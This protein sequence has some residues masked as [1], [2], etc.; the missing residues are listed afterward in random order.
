MTS[1]EENPQNIRQDIHADDSG[2]AFVQGTGAQHNNVTQN[3][4]GSAGLP[5]TPENLYRQGKIKL[6]A[7]DAEGELFIEAAAEAGHIEAVKEMRKMAS[8]RWAYLSEERDRWN[9]KLIELGVPDGY[10]DLA[11]CHKLRMRHADFADERMELLEKAISCYEKAIDGG[12][13]G[14]TEDLGMLLHEEGMHEEA[15][16]YLERAIVYIKDEGDFPWDDV[17]AALRSARKTLRSQQR[18]AEREQLRE[19]GARR[20]WRRNS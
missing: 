20:W 14:A 10:S 9:L 1:P 13:E 11:A 19:S 15:I 16:P 17:E 12:L 18:K 7:G 5:A 2:V 8:V 3:Y 4:Y 6:K